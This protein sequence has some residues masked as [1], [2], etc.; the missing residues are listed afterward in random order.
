MAALEFSL[1]AEN[2]HLSVAFVFIARA[3][4]VSLGQVWAKCS[5]LSLRNQYE[6]GVGARENA[7][8]AGCELMVRASSGWVGRPGRHLGE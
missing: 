6:V 8:P 2:T 7:E 4:K 3:P 5:P 1:N